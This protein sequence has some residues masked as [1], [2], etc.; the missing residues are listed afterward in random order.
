MGIKLPLDHFF[1]NTH[2]RL[3]DMKIEKSMDSD[4][5]P[6]CISLVIRS[7]D[8]TETLDSDI[9]ID[10]EVQKKLKMV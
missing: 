3:M 6:N 2:F 10:E 4:R 7:K 8:D 1:I 9:E 5:F